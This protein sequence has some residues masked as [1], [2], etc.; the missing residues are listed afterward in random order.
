MIP[1]RSEHQEQVHIVRWANALT[2]KYPELRL[3]YAIPNGGMRNVGV[4]RKLK[5]EGVKAGIPDLHLPVSDGEFHSLYIELKKFSLKPKRGG[6][7]GVSDKQRWWI[8][9]LR[10]KGHRVVVCYGANEAIKII[11]DYIAII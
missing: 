7:G 10:R 5:A 2:A 11:E 6:K 4:A 1:E 9:E 3:L 8:E